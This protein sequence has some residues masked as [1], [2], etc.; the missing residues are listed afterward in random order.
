MR[1]LLT[2]TKQTTGYSSGPG[3][4]KTTRGQGE[5]AKR[6]NTA[7]DSEALFKAREKKKEIDENGWSEEEMEEKGSTWGSS[8]LPDCGGHDQSPREQ[9]DRDYNDWPIR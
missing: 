4:N 1:A 5:R 8:L 6:G 9:G 7:K 3:P 2:N